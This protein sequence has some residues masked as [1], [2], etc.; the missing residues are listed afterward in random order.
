[1]QVA[2][3]IKHK[4]A[5]PSELTTFYIRHKTMAEQYSQLRQAAEI[6]EGLQELINSLVI[7]H[8]NQAEELFDHIRDVSDVPVKPNSTMKNGVPSG[9]GIKSI[10][11]NNNRAAI[12]AFAVVERQLMEDYTDLLDNPNYSTRHREVFQKQMDRL[13]E[14]N[15]KLDRLKATGEERNM[16]V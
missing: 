8:T 10:T 14:V 2:P 6:E 5:A 15:D 4:Q 3:E 16:N 7:V 11:P 1:M 9:M 13:I 12:K